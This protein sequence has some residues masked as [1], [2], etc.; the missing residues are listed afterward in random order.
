MD[1]PHST[2][3]FTAGTQLADRALHSPRPI[4]VC[5]GTWDIEAVFARQQI[6]DH[7]D[8]N[9]SVAFEKRFHNCRIKIFFKI[10]LVKVRIEA[11]KN[12]DLRQ[13]ESRLDTRSGRPLESLF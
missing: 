10:D 13:I 3:L 4:Q 7:D 1:Q 2:S 5:G 6:G 11:G 9:P 8:G 12:S